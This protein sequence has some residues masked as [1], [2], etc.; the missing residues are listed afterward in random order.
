MLIK[1][2]VINNLLENKLYSELIQEFESNHYSGFI[3]NIDN[4]DYLYF[5]SSNGYINICDLYNKNIF[6]IIM[7]ADCDNKSFKIIDMETFKVISEIKGEHKNYVKSIKKIYHPIYGESL[8]S[9]DHDGF[10]KLW[11]I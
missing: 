4:K 2:I 5:S 8:L 6:K 3:K 1:K 9:S 10:I 11:S 7:V